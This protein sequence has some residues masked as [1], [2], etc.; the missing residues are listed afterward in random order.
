MALAALFKMMPIQR[1]ARLSLCQ[2]WQLWASIPWMPWEK[3]AMIVD[4]YPGSWWSSSYDDLSI[5]L[6]LFPARC[7]G[8]CFPLWPSRGMLWWGAG[9]ERGEAVIGVNTVAMSPT[10]TTHLF[11]F[12]YIHSLLRFAWC[13]VWE[14]LLCRFLWG[15]NI[16]PNK[17]FFP[18][19]FAYCPSQSYFCCD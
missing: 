6:C 15:H 10:P 5:I 3:H 9:G 19:V 4:D 17:N 12:G 18:V 2:C 14:T 1:P 13:V 11:F 8:K 16:R 7:E